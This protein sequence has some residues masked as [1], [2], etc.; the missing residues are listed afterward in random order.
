MID[1]VCNMLAVTSLFE[2]RVGEGGNKR[3]S[4]TGT[5]LG[6]A[7]RPRSWHVWRSGEVAGRSFDYGALLYPYHFFMLA[8]WCII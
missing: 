1:G 6:K 8:Y 5:S 4:F 2:D 3:G 7:D